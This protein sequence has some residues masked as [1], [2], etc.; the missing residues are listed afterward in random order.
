[1]RGAGC[2]LG[3]ERGRRLRR[4]AKRLAGDLVQTVTFA[5][6]K[7]LAVAVLR[8]VGDAGMSS[9]VSVVGYDDVEL[10]RDPASP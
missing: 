8:A 10:D 7:A 1:L 6:L 2:G 3:R 4:G 9:E 5:G